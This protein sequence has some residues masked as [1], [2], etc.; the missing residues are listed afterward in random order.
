MEGK[1]INEILTYKREKTLRLHFICNGI[2]NLG[3]GRRYGIWVQGCNKRCEGCLAPNAQPKDGG[4]L[5]PCDDIIAEIIGSKNIDGITISGGEPVLQWKELYYIMGKVKK[6]NP[7]INVLLYTGYSW[8]ADIEPIRG[9]YHPDTYN[10]DVN[11]F[12]DFWNCLDYWIDG[13]YQAKRDDGKGLRGSSNQQL[14]GNLS[15]YGKKVLCHQQEG[16]VWIRLNDNDRISYNP[17]DSDPMY[18]FSTSPRIGSIQ[19]REDITC[20]IG[21]PTKETLDVFNKPIEDNKDKRSSSVNTT[22]DQ[23]TL[24]PQPAAKA[25][26]NKAEF[27]LQQ[28]EYN[29][30]VKRCQ[31]LQQQVQDMQTVLDE[32]NCTNSTLN[33]TNNDLRIQLADVQHTNSTLNWTNSHLQ[34]Q[35]ADAKNTYEVLSSENVRLQEQ[36]DKLD[37]ELRQNKTALDSSRREQEELVKYRNK[38]KDNLKFLIDFCISLKKIAGKQSIEIEKQLLL[39]KIPEERKKELNKLS[40]VWE[41]IIL[42]I[43]DF[44]KQWGFTPVRPQSGDTY[45]PDEDHVDNSSSSTTNVIKELVSEGY[46]ADGIVIKQAVVRLL[47]KAESRQQKG[48]NYEAWD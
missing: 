39:P 46:K 35:L 44:I 29:K 8:G 18:N 25:E 42:K 36:I 28:N 11:E 34:S 40:S 32:T 48:H 2:T 38:N 23:S 33:R 45:N 12:H 30:L 15:Y 6:R 10:T 3:P 17:T 16:G 1:E 19:V 4:N 7:N 31:D 26:I 41:S 9:Y 37:A 22:S 20:I 5:V 27:D 24:E 13:D 43:D 14:Y 21:I 47:E